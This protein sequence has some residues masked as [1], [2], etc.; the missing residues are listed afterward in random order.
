MIPFTKFFTEQIEEEFLILLP[1]GYKPPTAGHLHLIKEYCKLPQVKNILLLIG[2]K[3]RDGFTREQSLKVF[4]LYGVN[5]LSKV[6]V[7]DTKYD[8]PMQAAFE[9][10]ITDDRR[11]NYKDLTFAIGAST[12]G[13]DEKRSYDFVKYFEKFPEKLPDG[14]KVGIP[15]FVKPHVNRFGNAVSATDLR[16]A[17]KEKDL[18][19]VDA[20]IPGGTDIKEFLNIFNT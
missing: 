18:A 7:E 12:K 3:E 9:F 17:I 5:N 4:N 2:P 16:K 8:N 15:P 20:N 14:F 6:T 1:G 13:G 11:D 19:I 10:L